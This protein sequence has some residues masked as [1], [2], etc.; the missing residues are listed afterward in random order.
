M[1][2][3]AALD[4]DIDLDLRCKT[5]ETCQVT[6]LI[7][8]MVGALFL[9]LRINVCSVWGPLLGGTVEDSCLCLLSSFESPLWLFLTHSSLFIKCLLLFALLSPPCV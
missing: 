5:V 2:L 8:G 4:T 7:G 1:A 9:S 3:E 6:Q